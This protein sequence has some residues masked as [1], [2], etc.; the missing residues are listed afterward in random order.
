MIA[1][2][3]VYGGGSNVEVVTYNVTFTP[4]RITPVYTYLNENF[5]CVQLEGIGTITTVKN[6][7]LWIDLPYGRMDNQVQPI[8]TG[9]IMLKHIQTPDGML[10]SIEAGGIYRCDANG[11]IE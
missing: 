7:L 9:L 3:V 11:T 2:P 8:V 6:S 5:E 4:E 1:N 10:G